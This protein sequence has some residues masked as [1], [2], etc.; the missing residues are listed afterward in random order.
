M[1]QTHRYTLEEVEQHQEQEVAL[2]LLRQFE[3]AFRR[4]LFVLQWWYIV[5]ESEGCAAHETCRLARGR[6]A[7]DTGMLAAVFKD[8][9][10]HSRTC[11][12]MSVVVLLPQRVG[13]ALA[14]YGA[15]VL[16]PRG[17]FAHL[18]KAC[19]P[20]WRGAR[21]SPGLEMSRVV[22]SESGVVNV[23]DAAGV[24]DLDG[25]LGRKSDL[26]GYKKKRQQGS[27]VECGQHWYSDGAVTL[28]VPGW[29]LWPLELL[30]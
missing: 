3:E 25:N 11:V 30:A 7:V 4:T 17:A 28:V 29:E 27:T 14:W 15:A 10:V 6:R 2:V 20:F 21:N 23:G 8:N 22:G 9:A 13:G 24:R 1:R 19:V 12:C 18:W 16:G 26:K 5:V